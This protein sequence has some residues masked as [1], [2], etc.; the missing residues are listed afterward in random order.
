MCVM[1]AEIYSTTF[2]VVVAYVVCV[3]ICAFCQES[4][5]Q[6]ASQPGRQAAHD[7]IHVRLF[8]CV[9]VRWVVCSI[10]CLAFSSSSSVFLFARAAYRLTAWFA[11]R[12]GGGAGTSVFFLSGIFV[13]LIALINTNR[14]MFENPCYVA[15]SIVSLHTF[16]ILYIFAL[17]SLC[18]SALVRS[19]RTKAHIILR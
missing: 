19:C 13:R 18:F 10:S 14:S 2:I 11:W 16:G 1:S 7:V 6:P 15:L 3:T 8:V 4:W 17:S 9:C 12:V 5:S